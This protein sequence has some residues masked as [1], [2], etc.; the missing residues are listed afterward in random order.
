MESDDLAS[1]AVIRFTRM[2]SSRMRTARSL[3]WGVSVLGGPLSGGGLCQEDPLPPVNTMNDGVKS[4]PSAG[5]KIISSL[6]KSEVKYVSKSLPPWTRNSEEIYQTKDQ[7]RQVYEFQAAFLSINQLGKKK[8]FISNKSAK[9]SD[10]LTS[11]NYDRY[12][13]N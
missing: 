1:V 11:D 8:I 10:K 7:W 6:V 2:H 9:T 13:Y 4:L 12:S 5:G 3:P